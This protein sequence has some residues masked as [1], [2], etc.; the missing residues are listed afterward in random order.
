MKQWWRSSTAPHKAHA[1]DSE[2]HKSLKTLLLQGLNGAF[3]LNYQYNVLLWYVYLLRLHA[4]CVQV[5][6][7]YRNS[8]LYGCLCSQTLPIENECRVHRARTKESLWVSMHCFLGVCKQWTH[9]SLY[10]YRHFTGVSH[11]ALHTLAPSISLPHT[12]THPVTHS[13]SCLIQYQ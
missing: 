10:I 1:S 11:L 2:T 12:H 6:M 5:C 13:C 3:L 7:Y 9:H 8:S 4:R